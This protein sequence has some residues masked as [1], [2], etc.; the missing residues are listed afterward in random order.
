MFFTVQHA[1]RDLDSQPS[2]GKTCFIISNEQENIC[3][4]AANA[5]QMKTVMQNQNREEYCLS[6]SVL[7]FH[8]FDFLNSARS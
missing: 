5:S 6:V 4:S 7:Y 8:F 1:S 3:F 2:V